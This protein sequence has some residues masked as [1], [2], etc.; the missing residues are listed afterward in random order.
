MAAVTRVLRASF[1]S[2]LGSILQGYP[3]EV[4]R[5]PADIARLVPLA[6]V[7]RRHPADLSVR[8]GCGVGVFGLLPRAR[9]PLTAFDVDVEHVGAV[10]V[11]PFPLA[12]MHDE[13]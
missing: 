1:R 13:A 5:L 11:H 7:D 4:N 9:R 12:G 3:D 2:H 10:R 6:D 8:G